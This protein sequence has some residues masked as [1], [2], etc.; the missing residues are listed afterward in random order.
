M[1]GGC[2]RLEGKNAVV[3]GGGSGIGKAGAIRMAKEGANIV[4]GDIVK[5]RVERAVAEVE[6]L[7]RKAIGF[8]VDASKPQEIKKFADDAITAMEHIDILVYSAGVGDKNDPIL[9]QSLDK[10]QWVFDVNLTGM[11]LCC[12][13]IG[14]HMVEKGIKGKI[15]TFSS[16][17][18]KSPQGGGGGAYVSSKAAVI[19][20]T[21]ALAC[22]LAINDINVNCI[23]P[24]L[25]DTPIWHT[26]DKAVNMPEGSMVKMVAEQAMMSG[27][28]PI[29]RVGKP[30]DL[31]AG[32]AFLASSDSDYITGQAINICGGLEFH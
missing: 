24:G 19:G 21:K 20:F 8:I 27:Q 7:G 13:I 15:I 25:I 2:R 3:L 32:I 11:F 30:E 31:A 29:Q 14:R 9:E 18:G 26:G 5:E 17:M 10:W 1:T 16:T 22:E 28:L 4:I 12:Q 23:C 6:K